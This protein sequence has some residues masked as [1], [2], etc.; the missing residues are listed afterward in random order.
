MPV[1][2]ACRLPSGQYADRTAQLAALAAR[3]LRARATTGAGERL[4]FTDTPGVEQELRAVMAAEAACCAFLRLD[5]RR[6][7]DGLVLEVTGPP[8]ARPIIAALFG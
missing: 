7:G 4:V 3:A 8:D 2:I 1:P 6:A 5:L